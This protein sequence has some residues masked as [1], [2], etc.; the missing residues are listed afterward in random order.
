MMLTE[1]MQGRDVGITQEEVELDEQTIEELR[2]LGY[3]D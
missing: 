2:S 3:L 1:L